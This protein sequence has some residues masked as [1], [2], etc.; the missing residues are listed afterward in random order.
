MEAGIDDLHSRVAE[1]RRYDASTT[2]VPVE[3]ANASATATTVNTS[4]ADSTANCS[5]PVAIKAAYGGGGRGIRVCED[6]I[7]LREDFAIAKAEAAAAFKN[8]ELYIEKYIENPRHI[9]D[10]NATIL[11]QLGIDHK[12]LT[13]KFQGLDERPTG[14]EPCRVVKEILT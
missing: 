2:V 13:F 11:H 14:V 1:G 4:A 6:E 7:A 12:K 9:R 10:L 5:W 8:D 3:G